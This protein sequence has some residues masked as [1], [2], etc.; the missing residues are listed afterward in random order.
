MCISIGEFE[1]IE[2]ETL[3][4][5]E[6]ESEK[7]KQRAATLLSDAVIIDARVA[8][9]RAQLKRYVETFNRKPLYNGGDHIW[10]MKEGR[11]KMAA[12]AKE[13]VEA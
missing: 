12:K 4:N 6:R 7:M 3:Q 10:N 13:L 2:K 1:R 8:S 5:L 11:E 9:G